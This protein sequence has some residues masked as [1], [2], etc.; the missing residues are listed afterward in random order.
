MIIKSLNLDYNQEPVQLEIKEIKR[1]IKER[2][3]KKNK[4]NM[5]Q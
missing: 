2:N 4:N 3:K 1:K 5:N